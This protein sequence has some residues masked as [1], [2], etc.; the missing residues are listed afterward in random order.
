MKKSVSVDDANDAN[1]GPGKPLSEEQRTLLVADAQNPKVW[2]TGGED[3]PVLMAYDAL[4]AD[5]TIHLNLVKYDNFAQ[6]KAN[7]S[8][9]KLTL[10]RTNNSAYENKPSFQEVTWHGSIANSEIKLFYQYATAGGAV[11]LGQGV[12]GTDGSW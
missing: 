4:D 8:S 5:G 11:K 2:L 10:P 3:A 1:Y 6:M 9:E 7:S 12:H